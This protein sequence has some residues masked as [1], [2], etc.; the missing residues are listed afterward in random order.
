MTALRPANNFDVLRLI[1]AVAVFISHSVPLSYPA[2]EHR[3]EFLIVTSNGQATLGSVSLT[4]FFVISGYLVTQSYDRRRNARIFLMGRALRILPALAVML[5]LTV[6]VFAPLVSTLPFQDYFLDHQTYRYFLTNISLVDFAARLPGVFTDNPFP[7]AVNGS[8]WT[9]PFEVRCYAAVLL[10]GS[11]RLLNR[12]TT[13]ALVACGCLLIRLWMFMPVVE[14]YTCFAA[15]A[16]LHFCNLPRSRA[17]AAICAALLL[18]ALVTGGF[19]IVGS[20]LGA[21]LIIYL[22]TA[23]APRLLDTGKLGDLSYGIYIWAFPIQ[24]WVASLLAERSTWYLN[25]LVS[26]PLVCVAS[27]L[28][29]HLVEAPMLRLKRPAPRKVAT[30][31]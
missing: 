1:A 23:P 27:L 3:P 5:F 6:F 13:L 11:L 16:A 30:T 18:A 8:L 29:W 24:Q 21:Y 20:T 17:A 14:Y 2:Y 12:A 15:G 28:S 4:I 9:L 25:L 7:A 19:R 31:A 26:L 22:A 10:L